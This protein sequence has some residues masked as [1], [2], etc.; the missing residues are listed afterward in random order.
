MAE[1]TI[2]MK[3][4]VKVGIITLSDRASKGI[5]EDKSGPRIKELI[6]NFFRAESFES[7]FNSILIEDN[8]ALLESNVKKMVEGQFDI[9]FTCGGTGIGAR[10]ITPDVI[11]PLLDKEING[12]M[13]FIRLKYGV[14]FPDALLSRS[15]AGVI[16]KT[17]IYTL[18]GS[19]KA[20]E[21]YC[22]E[23]QKT[24][25]HSLNVLHSIQSH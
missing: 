5:Y 6:F 20:V 25:I 15:I 17:L 14:T 1:G 13:D 7:S 12:I 16:N 18:P 9:I 8:S 22:F 19:V 24:L 10:D 4:S 23:I 3:R 21:E 11:R 2:N